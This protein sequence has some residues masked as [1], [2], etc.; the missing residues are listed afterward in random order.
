MKPSDVDW[1]GDIPLHWSV[2]GLTKY[3]KSVVDYRGRTPRKVPEGVFLITARNVREGSID[4]SVS[5]EFIDPDEYERTMNRGAI[6]IGDVVFTTEAP[7]G[8]VA[9]LDRTDVALAQRVIK[10]RGQAGVLDNVFLKYWMMGSFCQADMHRLATGSTALGIKGS[11]VGQ[12]RLCLPPYIE[13]VDIVRW[14][15][16]QVS[17]LDELS[18]RAEEAIT[19]LQERRAALISASVTGQIDVRHVAGAEAA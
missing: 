9:N 19:L 15:E 10:L 17:S 18:A 3:L 13:Q 5:E 1:L 14:I 2:V 8:Q 7:L 6:A 16:H 4:Y 12:L 11:K